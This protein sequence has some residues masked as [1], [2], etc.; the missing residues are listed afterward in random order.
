[1][2]K[3]FQKVDPGTLPV[4]TARISTASSS[5]VSTVTA[6]SGVAAASAITHSAV[7]GCPFS[8]FH[9]IIIFHSAA[10]G[11]I[12]ALVALAL[13]PFLIVWHNLPP[14]FL[15]RNNRNDTT[16]ILPKISEHQ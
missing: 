2:I 9:T 11:F 4:H 16:E 14:C 15:V 1:L 6:V 7:T 5:A 8:A 12:T 13:L 3:H 10:M